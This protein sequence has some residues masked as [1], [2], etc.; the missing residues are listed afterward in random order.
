MSLGA[1]QRRSLAGLALAASVAAL[2]AACDPVDGTD[3][4]ALWE[5]QAHPDGAF[6]FHYLAPPWEPADGFSDRAPVLLLDPTGEPPADAGDPGARVRLEAWQG[7]AASVA[8]AAAARRERWQGAGYAVA[9]PETFANAAG[10]L[11]A[12]QR[13]AIGETRVVEVLFDTA[14]GVVALSLWGRGRLDAGDFLL[15]LESFEPRA[16][17]EP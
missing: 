11:G 17:A 6:H 1:G 2:G 12:V 7:A 16:P 15:L 9:A 8:E 14:D 10:D 13:A 5:V 3:P 4:Y